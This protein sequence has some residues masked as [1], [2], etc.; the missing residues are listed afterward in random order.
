MLLL[1]RTESKGLTWL[2]EAVV[3]L[4]TAHQLHLVQ[5]TGTAAPLARPNAKQLLLP[6]F[7]SG[8]RFCRIMQIL[9]L[10]SAG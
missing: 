9:S 4:Q 7:Q 10:P 3:S 8:L 6:R 2:T 5:V 1:I